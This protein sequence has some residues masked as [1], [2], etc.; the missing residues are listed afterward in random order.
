MV[1]RFAQPAQKMIQLVMYRMYK[2]NDLS[3]DPQPL[4][5]CQ[6]VPVCICDIGARG[7]K[8][9]NPWSLL[10]RQPSKIDEL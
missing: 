9:A 2:H 3:L 1:Y 4:C 6:G 10:I 8:N 5:K 7:T